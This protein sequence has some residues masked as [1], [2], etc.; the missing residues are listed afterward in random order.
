MFVSGG[1]A[2]DDVIEVA[3]CPIAHLFLYGQNKM[4]CTLTA[5][6]LSWQSSARLVHQTKQKIC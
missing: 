3:A 4:I 6:T 1:K 2:V 5:V